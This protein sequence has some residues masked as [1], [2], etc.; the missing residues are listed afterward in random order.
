MPAEP[1]TLTALDANGVVVG[2][3]DNVMTLAAGEERWQ[4]ISVFK[5]SAP[6]VRVDFQIRRKSRSAQR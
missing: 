3:Y 1:Y 5:A 6:P 4:V 2:T